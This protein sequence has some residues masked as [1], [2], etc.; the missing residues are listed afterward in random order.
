MKVV[1]TGATGFVG[2][3]LVAK[4][5]H[6]G[7]AV[8]ALAHRR[9]IQDDFEGRVAIVRGSIDDHEKLVDAFSG[10]DAVWHLVGIISESR[11]AT[12]E[13][14]VVQGTR[15]VVEASRKA[16]VKWLG[17]MSAMGTAAQAPSRYHQ[18][19]FAAE[20]AVAESGIDFVILRPSV[21][22]GPGDGFVSMLVSMLKRTPVV[23]VIGD[24][25]YRLQ[26]VFIEDLVEA[27]GQSLVSD[28]ALGQR[29]D[30]GGPEKLEYLQILDII[31]KVLGL[32]R[33]LVHVPVGLM[34]LMVSLMEKINI[35]IPL[36]SDQLIMMQMGNT[37]DI[38]QMK[39][40]LGISPT[41]LSDGLKKYLR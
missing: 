13:S 29:I 41:G 33:P 25:R 16:D 27:A 9:A 35:P 28:L 32:H 20:Q 31:M 17:F 37:G 3:H 8:T 5:L 6:D 40:I 34:K 38:S 21:I 15:N 39:K 2:R 11:T 26:P 22:F 23:P 12:F 4:L 1:V 18:T 14:T 36:T 24:G 30:I 10:A 19:K 7:H